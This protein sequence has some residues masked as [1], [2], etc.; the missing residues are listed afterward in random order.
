V[1]GKRSA[2]GPAAQPRKLEHFPPL[3]ASLVMRG[4]DP[5]IHLLGKRICAKTRQGNREE[6]MDRRVKPAGDARGR[7]AR[8]L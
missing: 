6:S 2:Q 1:R 3:L 5:R 4:L 7:E 8:S